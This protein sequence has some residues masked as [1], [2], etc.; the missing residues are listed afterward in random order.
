VRTVFADTSYLIA[1]FNPK[2]E[3]HA[4]AVRL[5]EELSPF[6]LLTSEAVLTEFLNDFSARGA[7]LRSRATQCVEQLRRN[8]TPNARAATVVPQTPAIFA[9]AFSI[10][11]D[12][13]DQSWSLTDC[14]SYRIMAQWGVHEAL[15]HD[16]HFEQ[17]GFRALLRAR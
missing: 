13:P 10:Y 6:H 2:D 14:T 5:V 1:L 17:M 15:T 7:A 11:R 12:R 8:G 4:V 3:H 9:E 16:R